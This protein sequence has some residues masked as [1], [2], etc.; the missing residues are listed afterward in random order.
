MNVIK[1]SN[2]DLWQ[3]NHHFELILLHDN[4][5]IDSIYE[6]FNE[7]EEILN[8]LPTLESRL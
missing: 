1:A 5:H 2:V 8:N 4:H 6:I 3:D 7:I